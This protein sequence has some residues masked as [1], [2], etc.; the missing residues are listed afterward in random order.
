VLE[1]T[2]SFCNSNIRR[3][4]FGVP[5]VSQTPIVCNDARVVVGR[6]NT[7]LHVTSSA[8]GLHAMSNAARQ[9]KV[10]LNARDHYIPVRKSEL[11]RQLSNRFDPERFADREK[12]NQVC[13]LM[14]SLFHYQYFE[15][16]ERLRDDYYYFDPEIE[17]TARFKDTGSAH[18]YA[19]LVGNLRAVLLK[20]NYIEVSRKD[21][22]V[23]Q[24]SSSLLRVVAA[25]DDYRDIQLFR[26]GNHR[27]QVDVRRWFGL[28]KRISD[29]LFYDN[30]V[31]MVAIKRE[32][33]ITSRNQR[34]R[35]R[36]AR[37]RPGTVLIKYFRNI[38]YADLKMLF[39]RVRVKLNTFDKLLIAVP[40]IAG[41]TTLLSNL[42]PTVS[43]LAIV[44]GFYLG[45]EAT[46]QHDDVARAFAALSG[47]GALGG[48][49]MTQRIKYER[50][51]LKYQKQVSDNCYF[52]NISNNA[53]LF[54]YIIGAAEEQE[55]KEAIL[56]FYFLLTAD[57][58]HNEGTLDLTVENWL[59]DTFG[60]DIDFEVDDAL[61]KLQRLTMLQYDGDR[62][63]VPAL[64]DAL[65]AL[66]KIW[67]N[68][69]MYNNDAEASARAAV[70]V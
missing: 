54:D 58:P 44:A 1:S 28:R 41:A 68:F 4:I 17:Q 49:I 12:F 35:L 15:Q 52:R 2:G 11:Q 22:E 8:Q 69:F 40:A 31:I 64:D 29:S 32:E 25:T 65:V 24:H 16:L 70:T 33:E 10:N 62:L 63:M 34:R 53:G 18:D 57:M 36:R 21:I 67:D 66:D 42:L 27:E 20:A 61:A 26:R 48:L 5:Q 60:V 56:A 55:C 37:L 14:S 51:S 43:V 59:L 13:K 6:A 47:I 46:I 30:V 7:E 19:K 38:A 23:E 9:P 50:R 45:F 3:I 39:P